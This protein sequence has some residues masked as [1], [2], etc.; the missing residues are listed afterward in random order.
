M[1]V[2]EGIPILP[3]PII[4]HLPMPLKE[5][6]PPSSGFRSRN[7]DLSPVMCHE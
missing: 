2:R 3:I 6:S 4:F 5:T 7:V 1:E